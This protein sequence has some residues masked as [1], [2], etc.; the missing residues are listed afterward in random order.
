[1]HPEPRVLFGLPITACTMDDV[2]TLCAAAVRS[3]RRLLVGVVNAAKIVKLRRDELRHFAGQYHHTL[4][5]AGDGFKIKLQR[6]DLLTAQAP[7]EY[8]LQVW[9]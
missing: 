4:L 1:M 8:V 9:L 2:L 6:V 3:R 7:F 5:K